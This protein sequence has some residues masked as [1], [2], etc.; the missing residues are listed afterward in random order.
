MNTTKITRLNEALELEF[1]LDSTKTWEKHG[2]NYWE[3]MYRMT[4]RG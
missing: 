1:D 4:I 2:K 3:N